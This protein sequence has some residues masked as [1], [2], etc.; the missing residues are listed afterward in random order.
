MS[1]KAWCSPVRCSR[2]LASATSAR[3]TAIRC[4]TWYGP[5][6][7]F[8]SSK[9]RSFVHVLT[10]KGRGY[11]FAQKEPARYHGV[12]GFDRTTGKIRRSSKPTFSAAF[13]A[14]VIRLAEAHPEVVAVTAAM[15]NGTGLAPF[16]R[17]FPHR[18]FDVGI[19]EEHAVTF[20]GGL[21]AGGARPVCAI[22]ATF[23]Q[24][25]LDCVYHDVVLQKLPVI[26]ALDRA[27]AGRGRSHPPRNLRSR[28]SP[29]PARTA[30]DGAEK[31]G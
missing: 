30:G 14:S 22:Y 24:R 5:F 25:A 27:G 15:C 13:G 31:R 2:S 6:N 19:A 23:M 4:R 18:C 7:G 17:R 26:F 21:A 11:E 3:S 12:P 28:L 8:G 1:S 9:D 29:R 16:A 10:E 20:S